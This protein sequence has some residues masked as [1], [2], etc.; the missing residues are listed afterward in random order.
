METKL[1]AII[2]AMESEIYFVREFLQ[3]RQGWIISKDNFY[4][5]SE[6]KIRIVTKILGVGKVNAAYQVADLIG[7][8]HPDVIV[9]VGFAG[10]LLPGAKKGDVVIGKEYVQTDFRPLRDQHLP[11][12]NESPIE[13]R[14]ILNRLAKENGIT[15][16]EGKIATGDFFLNCAE[17]KKK[18]IEEF[19]A[20]AFDMESAAIA[21]VTTKKDT[22]FVVIRVLS[23]LADDDAA[24]D[25]TENRYGGNTN[26]IP[27]EIY[28][29]MLAVLLA[30]NINC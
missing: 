5:N 10:G 14:E 29:V 28:P 6:K 3:N 8:W 7:T 1:I 16:Y 9:N 23:D 30:E 15:A 20:I 4:E 17:V 27:Y 22:Q 19:H 24:M 12:I 18:I 26:R 13:Y 25:V 11:R 2:S 21:Q